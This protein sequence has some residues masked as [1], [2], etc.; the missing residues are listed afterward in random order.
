MFIFE[1]K[2]MIFFNILIKLMVIK[3]PSLTADNRQTEQQKETLEKV[4]LRENSEEKKIETTN[5]L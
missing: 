2:R 4:Q 3:E 1:P 5:T